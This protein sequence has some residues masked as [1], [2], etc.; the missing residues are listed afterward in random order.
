M[1]KNILMWLFEQNTHKVYCGE[2]KEYKNNDDL[3]A[4]CHG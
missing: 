3:L 1:L 2:V 4:M